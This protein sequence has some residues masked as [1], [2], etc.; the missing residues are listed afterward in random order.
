[1]YSTGMSYVDIF[2]LREMYSAVKSMCAER[3]WKLTI[4]PKPSGVA[5][6][7]LAQTIGISTQNLIENTKEDLS[8]IASNTDLCIVFGE[9]TTAASCFLD[10]GSQVVCYSRQAYP[11]H[12][13]SPAE[14]YH[15]SFISVH[16][17]IK[18]LSRLQSDP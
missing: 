13:W 10:A 14:G 2:D 16:E 4:R 1:M 12:Y 9:Y 15:R 3:K 7:V 18:F 17:L 8:S 6:S 5:P 11:E